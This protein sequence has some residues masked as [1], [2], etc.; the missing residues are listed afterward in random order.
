VASA[1]FQL[2]LALSVITGTCIKTVQE[3]HCLFHGIGCLFNR[4]SQKSAF[5]KIFHVAH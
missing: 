2:A 3:R 1:A 5:A 4:R